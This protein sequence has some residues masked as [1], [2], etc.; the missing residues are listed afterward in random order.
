MK[1]RHK[2]LGFVIGGLV[3]LVVAAGLILFAL[4]SNINL[5]FSPSQIANNEAPSGTTFRLGGMVKKDSLK[6]EADGLTVQFVVTDTARDV[7]VAYKGI[8]PDL[9]REGQGVVAQGKLEGGIFKADQVLAKHDETYM[10]PEAAD[11]I[12]KAQET[13]QKLSGSVVSK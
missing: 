10:P 6:R 8:L 3:T 9:F 13:N 5:F 7:L 1:A 4:Q 11:A 2:R 12:K